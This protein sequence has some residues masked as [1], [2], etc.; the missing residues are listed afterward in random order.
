MTEAERVELERRFEKRLVLTL[1]NFI[2]SL[3]I[4]MLIGWAFI[5]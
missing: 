4:G 1:V 2:V 3:G 5:W